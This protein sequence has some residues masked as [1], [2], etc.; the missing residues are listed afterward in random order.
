MFDKSN[1][2]RISDCYWPIKNE[3]ERYKSRDVSLTLK[4]HTALLDPC[5]ATAKFALSRSHLSG[6]GNVQKGT[7]DYS[8]THISTVVWHSKARTLRIWIKET[9]IKNNMS[10]NL[11]ACPVWYKYKFNMDLVISVWEGG[12]VRLVLCLRFWLSHF[13]PI[14][15]RQHPF[16]FKWSAKGRS[17][18][19]KEYNSVIRRFSLMFYSQIPQMYS[20][21]LNWLTNHFLCAVLSL[22]VRSFDSFPCDKRYYLK[23]VCVHCNTLKKNVQ[24]ALPIRVLK[25]AYFQP[26][27]G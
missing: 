19:R 23:S 4:R 2:R 21:E 24:C 12:W 16:Y 1:S 22:F 14:S 20:K 3:H 17:R 25:N 18:R 9:E 5:L 15:C 6:K 8:L 10:G 26:I 27:K 7:E 11:L 13:T